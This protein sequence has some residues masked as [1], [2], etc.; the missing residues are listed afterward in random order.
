MTRPYGSEASCLLRSS[1]LGARTVHRWPASRTSTEVM[2]GR[3]MRNFDK[4]TIQEFPGRLVIF[5]GWHNWD[6]GENVGPI[7]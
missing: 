2:A 5:T 4:L 1:D 7:I 3:C 6:I